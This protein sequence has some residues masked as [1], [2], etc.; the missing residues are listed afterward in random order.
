ML[1]WE[2]VRVIEAAIKRKLCALVMTQNFRPL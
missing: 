1:N 2:N